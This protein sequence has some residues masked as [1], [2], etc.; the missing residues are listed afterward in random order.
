M[1]VYHRERYSQKLTASGLPPPKKYSSWQSVEAVRE[2]FEN[3]SEL[4]Y[5]KDWPDDWYRVSL[6]QLEL[7]GGMLPPVPLPTSPSLLPLVHLLSSSSTA[8]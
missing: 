8:S 7:A 2:F 6:K 4:H 5:I 1:L 3:F